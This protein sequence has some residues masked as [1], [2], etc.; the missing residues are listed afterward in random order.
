VKAV[1]HEWLLDVLNM[2][3]YRI[4]KGG[5]ENKTKKKG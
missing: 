4:R 2:S 1:T 5:F 3:T